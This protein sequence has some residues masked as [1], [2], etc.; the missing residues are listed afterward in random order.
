[1]KIIGFVLL[2]G[3]LLAILMMYGVVLAILIATLL[4]GYFMC[5]TVKTW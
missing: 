4:L 3:S 5:S 1:M 2:I